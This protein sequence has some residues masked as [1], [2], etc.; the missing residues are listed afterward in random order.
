MKRLLLA[1]LLILPV[2][3][4]AGAILLAGDSNIFI[5]DAD[6][7]VFFQNVF[8]GKTVVN[9]SSRSLDGL[10]TTATQVR[11]LQT[12]VWQAKIL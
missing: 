9:Y 8:N 7:E 2:Y 10:G 5:T 11:L 4:Q 3:A 12:R 6:N 1:F